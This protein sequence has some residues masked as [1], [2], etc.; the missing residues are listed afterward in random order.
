M[1]LLNP[2][3][4]GRDAY[5]RLPTY[6]AV[7]SLLSPALGYQELSDPSLRRIPGGGSDFDITTGSLLAPIL[8]PR[9]PGSAGS[10]AVQHHFVD[11]FRQQ[12]PEWTIEWQNS[13]SKTPATG[14]QEIP[15]HNLIL[16]REPP[17][18][19]RGDVGYLTL[20]AHYDS[21][22][23]PVGFI[24]AID[25][26]APCAMLMHVAR[27]IEGGLARK[28]AAMEEAGDGGLGLEEER[29][30]QIL[31]LDGE[32]AWVTW[33]ATD[34]IYGSRALAAH[35]DTDVYPESSEHRSPIEAIK[36][37]LLI[38][39]LGSP[40]PT[41]PSY[42]RPTHWFYQQMA[43]VERRMRKLNLLASKPEGVFLPDSGEEPE[44]PYMG[45][46]ADDH[47]PFMVRGVPILH[48]IPTPF[49]KLWHTMDDNG[50]HLDPAAVDDWAK[51]LT[52]F[53]AEWMELDGHLPSAH[54]AEDTIEHTEL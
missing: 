12:L 37:F 14:D 7:A 43:K 18:A 45:Y 1:L 27:S 30:V 47:V 23:E 42:F 8:V 29:G 13:T 36:L 2:G 44:K 41:V 3:R 25:S 17:W 9:V 11:F 35:W 51:I 20:A 22:F 52:A 5:L 54:D 50:E 48:I 21:L 33:T 32:E 39:L 40:D 31:L 34:S 6:L 38:D 46:I 16:R 49:P 15:F 10:A 24:G 4:P 53:A 26:A 19:K 28:W